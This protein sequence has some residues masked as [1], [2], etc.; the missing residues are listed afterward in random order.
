MSSRTRKGLPSRREMDVYTTT[1]AKR[2]THGVASTTM[3]AIK[4]HLDGERD[5][6]EKRLQELKRDMARL[7]KT[8][9][10]IK[11]SR[12]IPEDIKRDHHVQIYLPEKQRIEVEMYQLLQHVKELREGYQ[13]YRQLE[14]KMQL[15][16][17]KLWPS[18]TTSSPSQYGGGKA[19][20]KK[21]AAKPRKRPG[22]KKAPA[23]RRK[24]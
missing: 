1:M 3:R 4:K 6:K 7:T 19:K 22:A 21:K 14:G 10:D 13:R 2:R 9:S 5:A 17:K 15:A 18:S 16:S 20:K 11:T 23:R 8:A 24:R 12:T